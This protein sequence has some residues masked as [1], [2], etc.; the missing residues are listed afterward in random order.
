MF[1]V[2]VASL[3][4]D[5]WGHGEKNRALV[6]RVTDGGSAPICQPVQEDETLQVQSTCN[7]QKYSHLSKCEELNAVQPAEAP[8]RRQE[9][10]LAAIAFES[11]DSGSIERRARQM[12]SAHAVKRHCTT[13]FVAALCRAIGL[14]IATTMQSFGKSQKHEVPYSYLTCLRSS[15]KTRDPHALA[16]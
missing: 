14:D 11:N 2:P 5:T 7:G 15:A 10:I 9:T 6:G 8:E 12:T 3:Q 16:W 4:A 1:G 13:S